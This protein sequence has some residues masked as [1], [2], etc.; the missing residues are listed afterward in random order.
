M[1]TLAPLQI[2]LAQINMPPPLGKQRN[3]PPPRTFFGLNSSLLRSLHAHPIQPPPQQATHALGTETSSHL[4]QAELLHTRLVGGDG[5]ALDAHIVL[6]R[7]TGRRARQQASDGELEPPTATTRCPSHARK[8][9][10]RNGYHGSRPGQERDRPPGC[11]APCRASNDGWVPPPTAQHQTQTQG[12]RGGSHRTRPPFR[13]S[14]FARLDGVG[15]VDGNLVVGGV[16]VGQ[17]QIVVLNL[18]VD[19]REDE[20]QWMHGKQWGEESPIK[21]WPFHQS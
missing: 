1:C 9:A 13:P 8:Q 12:H 5:R 2:Q 20:L 11:S 16:A 21:A 18:E 19:V 15:G 6:L 14:A 4:L 7:E 17:A 10:S 3:Q